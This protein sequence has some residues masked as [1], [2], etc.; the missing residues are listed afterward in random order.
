[1]HAS[2][3]FFT[4][5]AL[6]GFAT[7]SVFAIP[8]VQ[9][10]AVAARSNADIKATLD[11]LQTTTS[12]IIP[13]IDSA[14]ASG[15]TDEETYA[16]L[17][18]NLNAALTT[19]KDSLSGLSARAIVSRQSQDEI[20]QQTAAIVESINKSVDHIPGGHGHGHTGVLVGA[21]TH[22]LYDLLWNLEHLLPGI[23]A[24]LV[25]LLKDVVG[26]VVALLLTLLGIL[27]K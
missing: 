6:L 1:M 22:L 12:S 16:P 17:L 11:T 5:Y 23:V 8:T 26:V 20:A 18:E 14:V 25:F 10:G 2:S 21:L 3:I 27:T 13:Q 9:S 24:T 15:H 19:A 7:T 4:L